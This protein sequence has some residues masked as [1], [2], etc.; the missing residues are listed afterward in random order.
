MDEESDVQS[1]VASASFA[2]PY[3][4]LLKDDAS[5]TILTADES[6][7]L[8]EVDQSGKL[9]GQW[10]SGSLYEDSDDLLRLE[11]GEDSEDEAGN[12]L[13]FLLSTT[14]GLNVGHI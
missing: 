11:Y 12:V 2:D 7:D 9:K 4:L 5:I 8:D 3:I 14:G 13:M 6:G 1:S 10:T